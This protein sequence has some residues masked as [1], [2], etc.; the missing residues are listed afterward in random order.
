MKVIAV[1]ALII[2]LRKK[3]LVIRLL[4]TIFF[5]TEH[6]SVHYFYAH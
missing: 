5:Y 1:H 6:L 3:G 2:F 4:A